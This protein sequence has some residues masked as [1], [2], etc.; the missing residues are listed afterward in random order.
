MAIV[1]KEI[2]MLIWRNTDRADPLSTGQTLQSLHFPN[3]NL[4]CYA[5]KLSEARKHAELSLSIL[6]R[7]LPAQHFLLA[8]SK[9][10]LALILEEI[11]DISQVG[12]VTSNILNSDRTACRTRLQWS[13]C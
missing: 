10:I 6:G 12:L 7:H 1:R 11:A 3:L 2:G 13:R 8:F 4:L 9:N 5:V